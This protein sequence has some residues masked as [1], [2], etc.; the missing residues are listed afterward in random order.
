MSKSYPQTDMNF[1]VNGCGH[2]GIACTFNKPVL[3]VQ[4][5]QSPEVSSVS[6]KL[7]TGVSTMD[8][9]VILSAYDRDVLSLF[10][11]I[12]GSDISAR[13][14]ELRQARI[15]HSKSYTL[16]GHVTR[17]T[18]TPEKPALLT[19]DLNLKLF[20]E[21]RGTHVVQT[22]DSRTHGLQYN[23]FDEGAVSL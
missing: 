12:E 4:I 2:A 16:Y 10:G 8:C 17:I 15:Q 22:I 18:D 23:P 3:A 20:Q 7:C 21:Y 5:E 14:V 6:L 9:S 1:F 19:L 13:L 11:V